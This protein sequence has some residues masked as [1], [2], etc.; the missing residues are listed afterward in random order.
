MIQVRSVSA[1][2]HREL[3]KRARSRGM[4]LTA[5]IEEILEREVAR[6]EPDEVYR[7]IAGRSSVDLGRPAAGL[8]RDERRGR[9][10]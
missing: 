5:Y 6:P 10:R 4:T 3:A 2:L 9:S 7:R 1:R 8:I